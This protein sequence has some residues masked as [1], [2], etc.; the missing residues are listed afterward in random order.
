ML[1]DLRLFYFSPSAS[2]FWSRPV[3]MEIILHRQ[4]LSR[5]KLYK[6]VQCIDNI[7][8]NDPPLAF[9]VAPDFLVPVELLHSMGSPS[10]R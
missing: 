9:R 10:R 4:Q 3:L 5:L 7:V 2:H 8:I 1:F 6:I